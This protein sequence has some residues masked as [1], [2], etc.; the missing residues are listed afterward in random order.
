MTDCHH[1]ATSHCNTL[2]QAAT[3][4]NKLQQAATVLLVASISMR[5][6]DVVQHCKTLPNTAKHCQTL[7]IT[8]RRCKTLQHTAAHCSTL[9]H[10]CF[11]QFSASHVSRHCKNA[12]RCNTQHAVTQLLGES[13]NTRFFNAVQHCNT[14][15]HIA[16]DCNK[17]A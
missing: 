4:C 5:S 14:L 15:Q 11:W 10:N 1:H 8:A 2:Q 12:T 16:T 6:L 9:L 13:I 7:Q 3:S 17:P